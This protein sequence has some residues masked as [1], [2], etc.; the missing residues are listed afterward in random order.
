MKN[1]LKKLPIASSPRPLHH[2][3]TAVRL[4]IVPVGKKRAASYKRIFKLESILFVCLFFVVKNQ[5][6]EKD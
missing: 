1:Y 3:I 6:F 5:P 2:V 4:A